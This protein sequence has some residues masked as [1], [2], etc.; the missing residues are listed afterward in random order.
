MW[1]AQVLIVL[2]S[3]LRFEGDLPGAAAALD[4]ASELSASFDNPLIEARL[5]FE[6]GL[7]ARARGDDAGAE[8]L[9]HAALA[10]QVDAGLRPGVCATLEA[11]GV[12]A[13]DGESPAE[14]VRCLAA[15][16]ALR[17][18]IGLARRPIDEPEQRT[19]IARLREQ[20]GHADFDTNWAAASSLEVS[21]MLEYVSR[22]RGERKRPSSGWASLTPTE[23]RVVTLVAEGLTNPQI[24]ERMFIARGTAKVHLS[25]IFDKLGITTRAQLAA[26][27][28]A[29]K[30]NQQQPPSRG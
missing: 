23:L 13:A 1:T 19:L 16:D 20:L 14:A 7:L 24:A 10:R 25:H 15:A 22:A 18:S 21:E 29:R 11:L 4:E 8:D 9:L 3:A 30:I 27:A 12:A 6:Q 17:S 2:G 26:A 28:T 5:H